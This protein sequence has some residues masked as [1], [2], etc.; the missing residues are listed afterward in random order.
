[1]DGNDETSKG[2]QDVVLRSLGLGTRIAATVLVALLGSLFLGLWADRALGIGPYAV[3]TSLALGTVVAVAGCY[4]IMTSA[5]QGLNVS[6]AAEQGATL[7]AGG[8][9]RGL[10]FAAQIGLIAVAPLLTGLLLGQWL[11]EWLGTSPWLT[12]ALVML[13]A[14]GGSFGVW[15]LSSAFLKQSTAGM[16]KEER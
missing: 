8:P 14:I 11:D 9:A 4:R 7:P 16:D 15:R 3:L 13:G 5:V 12:L 6:G 10:A 1:M 2:L